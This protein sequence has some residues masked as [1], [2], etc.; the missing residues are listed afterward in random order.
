MAAFIP[1]TR[2]SSWLS[3]FLRKLLRDCGTHLRGRGLST[4]IRRL[5]LTFREHAADRRDDA[6]VRAALAEVIEHHRARPDGAH[7]IGDSLARDVGRRAMN[8]FKHRWS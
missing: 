1:S 7:G 5:D 6:I 8:R 4:E 3:A 2:P